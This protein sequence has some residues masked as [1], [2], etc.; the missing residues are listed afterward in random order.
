MEETKGEKNK[1]EERTTRAI[2]GRLENKPHMLS[3][4]CKQNRQGEK[5]GEKGGKILIEKRKT[6]NN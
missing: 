3:R 5:G 2:R 1:E 6:G 4:S